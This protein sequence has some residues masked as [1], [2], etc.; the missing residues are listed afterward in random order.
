MEALP[1]RSN[2]RQFNL[3]DADHSLSFGAGTGRKPTIA[4]AFA[5]MI[6]RVN[7]L[8]GSWLIAFCGHRPTDL[9][10]R[11]LRLRRLAGAMLHGSPA[12]PFPVRVQIETTDICNLRCIHCRREKLDDMD[13]LTMPLDSFARIIAD[14]KPLYANMAGF[15]EP[16]LDSSIAAKLH[17]LHQS[18]TR[19]SFPTNGTYIRRHKREAL[20]AELP[21]VLQL[22]IDGATKE[23]FEAIRK[24]GDFD[25]IIDNYRAICTL[26]ADG[27]TRPQ[28]IIRVLCALQRGNLH[29]YRAMYRL[30]KTLPGI[31]SFGLVPVSYGSANAAQIPN[32]DEILALHRELDEAV[33]AA[34]NRDEKGFYRQWRN[35]S[36][37]W[38]KIKGPDEGASKA[39][40]SPCRVPWFSTY[41]D[42][43]GRV[44]PCCFLTGT[45]HVMGTLNKDGSGFADIWSGG[46]YRTFRS[47]LVSARS[48]LEGC[49]SCPRNDAK[50]LTT[51]DKM[52]ALL[53]R[54]EPG[55]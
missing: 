32:R 40:R 2:F 53:P 6:R 14:I 18:G 10:A 39:N 15:G 38:L 46:R 13:T 24:L 49:R 19:S 43:K 34:K 20:A 8:L 52:R 25:K 27:K 3:A 16:L 35:V 12:P 21:D 23:S 54:S 45:G 28:T 11:L 51:L 47:N 31:D 42:A 50:V 33:A 26:R 36:A 29:D 41:I 30:I 48:R 44:Y 9:V 1:D 37:E 22:S 5:A 55:V 7:P 17:I 4:N